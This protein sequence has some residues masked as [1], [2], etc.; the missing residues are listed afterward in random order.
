MWGEE[1]CENFFLLNCMSVVIKPNKSDFKILA[2]VTVSQKH[3]FPQT[4][5][6][7]FLLFS[8]CLF[9]FSLNT[10]V[11][12]RLSD[13]IC[14]CFDLV[15][16]LFLQTHTNRDFIGSHTSRRW[17]LMTSGVKLGE[18]IVQY[19]YQY[20]ISSQWMPKIQWNSLNVA[21]RL[22]ILWLIKA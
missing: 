19:F 1:V 8:C 14:T 3:S 12:G 21:T 16:Q 6:V 18:N 13:F 7:Q 2:D 11:V 22:F 5:I 9:G 20:L 17:S 15:W 4:K 10:D